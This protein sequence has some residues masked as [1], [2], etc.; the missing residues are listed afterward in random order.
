MRVMSYKGCFVLLFLFLSGCGSWQNLTITDIA[1]PAYLRR[2]E[3][4]DLTLPQI[5]KALYDYSAKCNLMPQ[6]RIDPSNPNAAI[7]QTEMMGLTQANPGIVIEF[8]QTGKQTKAIGYSYYYNFAW[9]SAMER[10]FEAIKMP[11]KC[12]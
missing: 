3:V 7:L 12:G 2:T 5:Q 1:Q 10:I 6:L 4:L 9:P 8:M 11:S